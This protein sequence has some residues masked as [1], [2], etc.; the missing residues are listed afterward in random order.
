MN[1]WGNRPAN[2]DDMRSRRLLLLAVV[3]LAAVLVVLMREMETAKV[4]HSHDTSSPRVD[5][6][7][8][9]EL[10]KL[11]SPSAR[12]WQLSPS[13]KVVTTKSG[14]KYQDMKVGT[15]RSPK[16]ADMVFVDY[17][18]FTDKGIKVDSSFEPGRT[19][20]YFQLGT[21]EV[22]RGWEEGVLTM[23]VG[24]IRRLVVPPHLGYGSQGS[25]PAIKPNATLIFVVRLLDTKTE[26]PK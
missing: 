13:L 17:V 15:E 18:G 21:R 5:R 11:T 10:A 6:S 3:S 24:G 20:F 22:I 23:K 4:P 9:K 26:K 19:P 7:R 1:R 8:V 16:P 25:P 2:G 14:L 12:N